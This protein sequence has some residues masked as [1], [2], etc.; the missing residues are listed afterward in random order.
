MFLLLLLNKNNT[1]GVP[2]TRMSSLF[3]DDMLSHTAMHGLLN[4]II[5]VQRSTVLLKRQSRK[6]C[7]LIQLNT[8]QVENISA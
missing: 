3:F 1:K 7:S 6:G 8:V 5:Q 2:L 4:Q